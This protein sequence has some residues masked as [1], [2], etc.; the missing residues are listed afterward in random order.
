MIRKEVIIANK[1][2]LHARPASQFVQTA[3]KF[4]SSIYVEKNDKR[5]NGKSILS[6]LSGCITQGTKVCLVIEGQDESLAEDALVGLI[7]SNFGE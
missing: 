2:G 1:S 7:K 4:K 6:I 3:N 5:L